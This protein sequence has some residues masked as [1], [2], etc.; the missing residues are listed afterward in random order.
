M[1]SKQLLMNAAPINW[2]FK[3]REWLSGWI[4]WTLEFKSA[5]AEGKQGNPC[6]LQTSI[7]WIYHKHV[8]KRGFIETTLRRCTTLK[9]VYY[10]GATKSL[11]DINI[12]LQAAT[13]K[14]NTGDKEIHIV[15]IR[16]GNHCDDKKSKN[17]KNQKKTQ[18][19]FGCSLLSHCSW[20]QKRNEKNGPSSE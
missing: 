19:Y 9:Y 8:H 15:V 14:M 18:T 16:T 17:K 12:L 6:E 11:A 5:C 10:S 1:S 2:T 13:I 4:T 3:T 7:L 20:S